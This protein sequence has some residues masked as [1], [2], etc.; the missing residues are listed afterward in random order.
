M[1][2]L[3]KLVRTTMAIVGAFLVY[4]AAGTSDYY[5]IELGQ[6]E[7]TSVWTTIIVGLLMMS[8]ALAHGI[9]QTIKGD[10]DHVHH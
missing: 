1:S 6:L 3:W 10:S 2:Y 9:V 8:P 5:L 4:G 7:P